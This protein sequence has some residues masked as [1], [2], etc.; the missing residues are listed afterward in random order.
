M[1]RLGAE[2]VFEFWSNLDSFFEDFFSWELHLDAFLIPIK[3]LIHFF[4]NIQVFKVIIIL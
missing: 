1:A 3:K 4:L 2:P